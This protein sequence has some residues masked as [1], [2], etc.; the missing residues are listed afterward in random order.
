ME[1]DDLLFEEE[2]VTEIVEEKIEPEHKREMVETTE[3]PEEEAELSQAKQEE[4]VSKKEEKSTPLIEE[5]PENISAIEEPGFIEENKK[6][7]GWKVGSDSA[8][9]EPT[10]K[11][12]SAWILPVILILIGG[13]V[14][15][16]FFLDLNFGVAKSPV[17]LEIAAHSEVI[18]EPESFIAGKDTLVAEVMDSVI[19]EQEQIEE[20]IMAEVVPAPVIIEKEPPLKTNPENKMYTDNKKYT[21]SGTKATHTVKQGERLTVIALQYYGTK[22]LWPYIVEHNNGVITNPDVVPY[23]TVIKIPELK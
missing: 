12:R 15:L 11:K 3:F 10:E 20:E 18:P 7:E 21:I 13:I 2:E 16:F 14:A 9:V 19:L 23:G 4:P 5:T 8:K 17:S 1:F 22:K 6:E